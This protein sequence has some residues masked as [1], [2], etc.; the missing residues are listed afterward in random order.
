MAKTSPRRPI[1]G[2]L[3]VELVRST[4]LLAKVLEDYCGDCLY[5]AQLYSH[6]D[7]EILMK[8]IVSDDDGSLFGV[9]FQ[10]NPEEQVLRVSNRFKTVGKRTIA[11]NIIRD[12][13][14]TYIDT[15]NSLG[16]PPVSAVFFDI[17]QRYNTV[18]YAPDPAERGSIK[19]YLQAYNKDEFGIS[20]M[21]GAASEIAIVE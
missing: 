6:E 17:G 18:S 3:R 21:R 12:A 15:L 5:K 1:D 8:S 16:I 7:G 20:D 2:R 4:G 19:I 10:M 11:L 14:I 13:I 9:K